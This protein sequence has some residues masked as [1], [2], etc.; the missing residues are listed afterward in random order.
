MKVVL[1]GDAGV[2]KTSLLNRWISK[3]NPTRTSQTVAGASHT[4]TIDIDGNTHVI[5]FWDTAGAERV[6]PAF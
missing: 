1:L 5:Q 3:S 4:R 2:G 6:L